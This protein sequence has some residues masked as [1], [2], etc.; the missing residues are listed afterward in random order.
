VQTNNIFVKVLDFNRKFTSLKIFLSTMWLD[1]SEQALSDYIKWQIDRSKD[2]SIGI[3]GL[4]EGLKIGKPQIKRCYDNSIAVVRKNIGKQ[5]FYCEGIY[6]VQ[7]SVPTEHAWNRI[8]D[9]YFDVTYNLL[10]KDQATFNSKPA[11][12][13]LSVVELS[14]DQINRLYK[15]TSYKK[16]PVMESIYSNQYLL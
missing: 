6:H 5:V 13:Y 2:V 10:K 14:Y 9:Q 8:G 11:P 1:I 12:S 7:G 16:G 3:D 4:P 15:E